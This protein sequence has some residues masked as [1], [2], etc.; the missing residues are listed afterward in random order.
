MC[1]FALSSLVL[2]VNIFNA[3]FQLLAFSEF[4]DCVHYCVST[5]GLKNE[6]WMKL[7]EW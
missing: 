2:P 3:T 4:Y 7:Q 5:L 1:D 6:N